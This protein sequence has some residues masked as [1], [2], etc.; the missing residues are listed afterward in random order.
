M[1]ISR[2]SQIIGEWPLIQIK[3][4]LTDARL[5]P[6]DL[7]YDEDASEW[8][9]LSGLSA[10]LLVQKPVSAI[11][12]ACYCGSGLLFNVCHGDGSQY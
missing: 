1:R 7:F 9:P 8:L 6:S 4:R 12:R 11:S 5:V 2:G 3:K 10:R